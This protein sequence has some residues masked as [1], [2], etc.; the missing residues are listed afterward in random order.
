MTPPENLTVRNLSATSITITRI[1]TFPAPKI[2]SP[3]PI[4]IRNFTNLGNLAH[5]LTAALRTAGIAPAAHPTSLN[6]AESAK[7]FEGHDVRVKVPPFHTVKTEIVVKDG[8]LHLHFE[9]EN[10]DEPCGKFRAEMR[11]G[12]SLVHTLGTLTPHRFSGVFHQSHSHL[13]LLSDAALNEWQTRLGD[14]TLLSAISIP[15]THNSP[16]CYRALPSVRCQAVGIRTQLDN[17][18]R[19]FDIR[20][21]VENNGE[22]TLVHGAFPISLGY[23]VNKLQKLL[24]ETYGFLD[25]HPHEAIIVSLKREGRGSATDETFAKHLREKYI[26]PQKDRWWLDDT[27]V[28]KLGDVRGKCILFRRF[29]SG[30]DWKVGINAEDWLYNSA[31]TLTPGGNCRVQD[32]CE[33]IERPT[34]EKKIE[35]VKEHLER[36]ATYVE[37]NPL[38]L[39]FLSGSNFWKVGCWPERVAEKVNI[40]MR[41]HFAMDHIVGRNSGDGATGVVVCDFVGERGEWDLVRLIVAMNAWV[42]RST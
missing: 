35:Y 15:G 13:A 37:G 7:A 36:A 23:Q 4:T 10:G 16:T 6:L 2:S 25:D 9:V 19:F 22:L 3:N 32:F 40:E 28:P 31:D 8:D 18:I 24:D 33:V 11:S 17:G 42:E 20:C 39:N 14:E 34:I 26:E 41:R 5:H 27:H 29:K 1:A 38:F 12:S 30:D 21:Q